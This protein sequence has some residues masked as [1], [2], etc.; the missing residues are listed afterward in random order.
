MAT[1]AQQIRAYDG[2]LLFSYGFRPFFLL[3]AAWSATAVVVF[4][5]A[6]GG[7]ISLPST[8]TPVAWHT[9][10]MIYGFVPAVVAGFLLTAVPNWTGRLPVVGVRL[11]L[12]FGL[13][14]CGRIALLVSAQ[15]GPLI[16]AVIDVA[17][18]VALGAV[19]AREIIAAGN[20]RNLK[21]L[22][23][24]TLLAVGNAVSHVEAY[25]GTAGNYG[26]R[27]GIA[28]TILLI[29][30]IGGRIVPSFTRNWLA[31]RSSPAMPE[32][33]GRFDVAA[34]LVTIAALASWVSRPNLP[35]TAALALGAMAATG[36][37]LARWSGHRTTAEPLV[38][39][40]HIAFSFVPIGFGLVALS[41]FS[42]SLMAASGAVHAWTVGA[43]GLMT[44]AVMTRASLGHTGQP[45]V[46]TS[47]TTV[48]FC[49]VAVA[50]LTRIGVAFDLWPDILLGI[51][52]A[53]WVL[54][55]GGFV[56]V[57]GPSLSRA[58]V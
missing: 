22:A 39:V 51:S 10:E 2:P 32:P 8:F 3:G 44:L 30:L 46:A 17:F 25:S 42:P 52:A 50:A 11:A 34:T 5:L 18:L 23:V 54:G 29:N 45:L 53:A 49:A 24:I 21:V 40:L 35:V 4:I 12:L 19:I 20:T 37:R 33:F 7:S 56:V 6:L 41:V 55:F 9:H 43:I 36:W 47:K 13:W 26:V 15:I 58:R 1:S 28:G 48:L 14:V 38:L 16:T 57:Y 27:I 31:K